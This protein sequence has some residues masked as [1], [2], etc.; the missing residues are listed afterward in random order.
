MLHRWSLERGHLLQAITGIP[1]YY[2]Q[3]G[4]EMTVDYH[5][6][7]K[8]PLSKVPEL[9]DG[10]EESYTIR[11]ARRESDIPFIIQLDE[12][13]KNRH[14]LRAPCVRRQAEWR[15]I[16]SGM[17]DDSMEATSLCIIED[18]QRRAT[19]FLAHP[20]V[21]WS[22]GLFVKRLELVQARAGMS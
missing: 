5:G 10:E 14:L 4:Y 7:R 6:G 3:F 19:G 9:K 2:R 20:K 15:Y 22:E 17:S 18:R 8:I 1:Y 21:R 12:A 13:R 16:L 11:P